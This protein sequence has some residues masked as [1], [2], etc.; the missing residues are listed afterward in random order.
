MM[1]KLKQNI[2]KSEA[3]HGKKDREEISEK[4]I[5]R[6]KLKGVHREGVKNSYVLGAFPNYLT[7][8]LRN[9]GPGLESFR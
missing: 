3:R 6:L 8:V 1:K 7:L 4:I 2:P 5:E 9:S